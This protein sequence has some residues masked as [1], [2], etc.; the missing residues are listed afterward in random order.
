[1]T[2]LK[3]A[4]GQWSRPRYDLHTAFTLC[5]S[6]CDC[7][8]ASIG[9][10][11]RLACSMCSL[12]STQQVGN[13]RVC[14]G[15]GKNV[16]RSTLPFHGHAS[17]NQLYESLQ[18]HPPVTVMHAESR[19]SESLVHAATYAHGTA[20]ALRKVRLLQSLL[21]LIH[22]SVL[23][24]SCRPVPRGPRCMCGRTDKNDAEI[25]F[26]RLLDLSPH[27]AATTKVTERYSAAIEAAQKDYAS[28]RWLHGVSGCAVSVCYQAS[29]TM[30][31]PHWSLWV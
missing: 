19:H 16:V 1:M 25:K 26:P 13:E 3:I 10:T 9:E 8:V 23:T 2:S 5:D 6:H 27:L 12:F 21:V 30:W 4:S 29:H 11:T 20:Q 22:S 7:T 17:W 28:S 18:T 31:S 24:S 14:K 15:C